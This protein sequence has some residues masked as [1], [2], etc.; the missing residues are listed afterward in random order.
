MKRIL[1]ILP[2]PPNHINRIRTLNLLKAWKGHAEVHLV[3]LA[4]EK[5]DFESIKKYRSLYERVEV[6][7]HPKWLS[8]SCCLRGTVS[9]RP[10][11]VSYCRSQI[12]DRYLE[13]LEKDPFDVVYIKRLRMAQYAKHF[14]LDRVWIDLTDS[15]NLY[16]SRVLNTKVPFMERGIALYENRFLGAYE[17]EVMANYRTVFCSEVDL[18]HALNNENS[19]G[20]HHLIIPNVVDLEDFRRNDSHTENGFNICY[21]G[22]LNVPMNYTAVNILISEVFDELKKKSDHFRL[23][24][25]GPCPPRD[26]LDKRSESVVFTGHIEQLSRRLSQMNLFVCPLILGTGVKNKIL[27]SLALGVPVLTTSLGVEGIEGIERLLNRGIVVEDK[28]SK[29]PDLIMN[30]IPLSD[31]DRERMRRFVE[32]YYSIDALREILI[33]NNLL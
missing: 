13:N 27:Q 24:I 3:C 11:R 18:R 29:Y 33:Q 17:R 26:L 20:G 32:E 21:W 28:I 1:F 22:N 5:K 2:S 6:I 31:S 14:P 10:L 7:W 25:I 30:M 19:I 9:G 15:M 16:Y 12:L 8:L 4:K 23:E